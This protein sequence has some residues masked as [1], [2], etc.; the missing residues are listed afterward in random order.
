VAAARPVRPPRPT[1]RFGWTD[2]LASISD[3]IVVVDADGVVSDVNPAAELL[4]GVSASQAVGHPTSRAFGARSTNAWIAELVDDTLRESVTHR[5]AEEELWGAGRTVVVSAACAPVLDAAGTVRGVVLVLH[6]LTLQHAIEAATRRAERLAALDAVA[7]GLAHE[8][9]NPL[10]GIKGAAQLLKGSVDEPELVQC[11]DMIIREVERLVGLVDQLRD[12]GSPPPLRLE[13]VNIHRILKDVVDLQ[14]QAPEWGRT[15]LVTEFDPSLPP[16]HADPAQLHQVFLNLVKNALE[17]MKGQGTIAIATRMDAGYRVR[18][19]G[20]DER[21]LVVTVADNGPGVPE[22]DRARLFAPFFST[23][24]RG[25][26]LGL[27]LCQRIVVQHGGTI[28]HETPD[29]GGARFRITLPVS[30]SHERGDD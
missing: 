12:L 28:V 7:A 11:T 24:A 15:I 2:I 5:R 16:I 22:P 10:G 19:R 18:R 30:E 29:A 8:I 23:K 6:D 21:I 27:A 9:R 20:G 13:P 1:E 14:R 17:S 4:T 25:S 26:G 3:A